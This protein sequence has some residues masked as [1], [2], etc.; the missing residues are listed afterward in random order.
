MTSLHRAQVLADLRRFTEAR[1]E[2]AAYLA[3]EP[4]SVAGLCLLAQCELM[5]DDPG[6]AVATTGRVIAVAPEDEW[7][8]RV[9]ALALAKLSR[10]REARTVARAAVTAGPDNWRNHYV[11]ALVYT[12]TAHGEEALASARRA[13][14]LAPHEADAH[15][16]LGLALSGLGHKDQART[17]YEEALRLDPESAGALNNL[18]A[19]DINASRLGRGARNVAAGLRLNPGGKLLQRNL[20]VVALRL[21]RRLLLLL[22]LTGLLPIALVPAAADYAWWARAATGAVL[23]CLYALVVWSTLRHLPPGARLHLRGLPRR[24]RTAERVLGV[25]LVVL[26]S[27][28]LFLAFAPGPAWEVGAGVLGAIV[29]SPHFQLLGVIWFLMGIA[30]AFR[31]R[32]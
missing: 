16:V 25:I 31:R 18:A 9:R 5:T 8:L 6:R 17:A 28:F 30:Q 1:A 21:M 7:A 22:P 2:L 29:R 26:A 27:V 23:V 14:E 20:D 15:V 24:M 10:H 32:R 12:E 3:R 11:R 4:E 13:V 19:M